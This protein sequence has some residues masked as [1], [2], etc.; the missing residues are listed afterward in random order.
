MLLKGYTMNLK[1]IELY[2][3]EARDVH[4]ISKLLKE[5]IEKGHFSKELGE[6]E[7][8][9]EQHT[10]GLANSVFN[11]KN[12]TQTQTLIAKYKGNSVGF[13]TLSIEPKSGI[14]EFWMV[15]IAKKYRR[16]GIAAKIISDIIDKY[17]FQRPLLTAR[18]SINS[19]PMFQLL[20]KQNFE[21]LITGEEEG[22]RFL[23]NMKYYDYEEQLRKDIKEKM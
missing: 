5:G 11:Q 1:N 22:T 14:I 19:E 12:N 10:L 2:N 18:C 4:F 16:K 13:V 9:F 7:H 17:K 15:A 23:Y 8:I 6:D 3:S 21:H 20:L